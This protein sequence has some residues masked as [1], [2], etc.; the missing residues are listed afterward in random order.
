M[1]TYLEG[2][3]TELSPTDITLEV[4][5]IGHEIFIPLSSFERLPKIGS[6]F[7]ILTY[8]HVREDILRLYGFATHDERDLFK[9]LISISGIGPRLALIILSGMTVSVIKTAISEG[10]IQLLCKIPGVG[11]KTAQRIVIELKERI[12][13]ITIKTTQPIPKEKEL[14]LKDAAAALMNLGYKQQSAQRAAEK[15][16]IENKE[17]IKLEDLLKKTLKYL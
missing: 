10:D 3:L 6:R 12:G 13:G 16:L 8:L 9:L 2:T 4:N 5:G 11:R 14:L 15:A 7:R 17:I 1:I